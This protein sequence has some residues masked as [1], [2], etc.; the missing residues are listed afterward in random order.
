M[1]SNI[2]ETVRDDT[3][4]AEHVSNTPSGKSVI[5]EWRNPPRYPRDSSQNGRVYEERA[6]D[7]A[8][9]SRHPPRIPRERKT[10]A[11][12]ATQSHAPPSSS[13]SWRIATGSGTGKNDRDEKSSVKIKGPP[14]G[15][16]TVRS[17]PIKDYRASIAHNVGT[18]RRSAAAPQS[19]F[20]SLVS[21]AEK[22]VY[23]L[24]N[25]KR[26]PIIDTSSHHRTGSRTT[27][28]VETTDRRSLCGLCNGQHERCCTNEAA[29]RHSDQTEDRE[30]PDLGSDMG[31][32]FY[33][34]SRGER[35]LATSDFAR[36]PRNV[37]ETSPRGDS[38]TGT[39][40]PA[41]GTTRD[42]RGKARATETEADLRLAEGHVGQKI[43]AYEQNVRRS[44]RGVASPVRGHRSAFDGSKGHRNIGV[45]LVGMH[46]A[47]GLPVV[48]SWV[49]HDH[50]LLE[51]LRIS[52]G[53]VTTVGPVYT[54]KSR[55]MP[56]VRRR[57]QPKRK[58]TAPRE[59]VNRATIN[60]KD[61]NGS[62]VVR[63]RCPTDTINGRSGRKHFR[64]VS[65]F[66]GTRTTMGSL[67]SKNSFK[68]TV[69]PGR[70]Y[71]GI[72]VSSLGM[73]D[74]IGR[75]SL[76]GA[77]AKRATLYA[78]DDGHDAVQVLKSLCL[79][80]LARTNPETDMMW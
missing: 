72:K 70:G 60:P 49:N 14:R 21:E 24:S 78:R 65:S 37:R 56:N 11:K 46:N 36:G 80:P 44:S 59:S 45:P 58:I 79:N 20:E 57:T 66:T 13:S 62:A 55:V 30:S 63:S 6:V 39:I 18:L 71:S 77:N 74:T 8:T 75:R 47:C 42:E 43:T 26:T 5:E 16:D 50:E 19:Q 64:R 35:T 38:A 27:I 12:R 69:R 28:R 9:D 15:G 3:K 34:S 22:A 67:S 4:Y 73:M 54:R 48:A 76:K 68:R 41:D 40:T 29:D 53:I 33:K 61:R 17:I 32:Y 1:Q 10:I 31:D 52:R 23:V 7:V 25:T 51:P 2:R